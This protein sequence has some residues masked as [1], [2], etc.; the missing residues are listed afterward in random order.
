MQAMVLAAGFATRLKPLTD[1]IPKPLLPFW[2]QTLLS[3]LIEYLKHHGIQSTC[4]NIHH[5]QKYFLDHLPQT[6]RFNLT[7]FCEEK[8]LGTGG[9]IKNMQ[10]FVRDSDFFVVNSDFVTDIDLKEA[11]AFHKKWKA[12]ATVVLVDHPLKNKYGAIGVDAKGRI[13]QF[14]LIKA[15]TPAEKTGL[16]AGIHIFNQSIF[17]KMPLQSNFCIVKDVYAPLIQKGEPVFGFM[18]KA[19]W[20]DVGQIPRYA[21]AQFELLRQ[22]FPWME[23]LFHGF[24]NPKAS[25][26]IHPTVSLDKKQNIEGSLFI[27]PGVKIKSSVELR[28]NVIIGNHAKISK[29]CALKNTIIFPNTEVSRSEKFENLILFQDQ[30]VSIL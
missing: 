9:G 11:F 20:L 1:S 4:I 6:K 13:V 7:P 15:P 26:W 3:L 25:T 14:P 30:S 29:P 17:K 12:L 24:S 16:F 2:D 5:A 10:S 19:R 27:G 28:P 8:I 18:S 22:P 23:N 21:Q